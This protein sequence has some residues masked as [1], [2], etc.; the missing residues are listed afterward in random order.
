MF[1]IN[2]VQK[3]GYALKHNNCFHPET[4]IRPDVYHLIAGISVENGLEGYLLTRENVTSK[5]FL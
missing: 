4:L 5:I 1:S 2:T 3:K